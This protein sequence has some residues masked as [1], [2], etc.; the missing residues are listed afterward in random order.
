[1]YLTSLVTGVA[2]TAAGDCMARDSFGVGPR[3]HCFES[4]PRI[5]SFGGSMYGI[6]V[7][8]KFH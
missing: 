4:N 2:R 5:S 6:Q 8:R 1:M 3:R 7:D